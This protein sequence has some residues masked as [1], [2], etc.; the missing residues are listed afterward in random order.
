[1]E[2]LGLIVAKQL[3]DLIVAH[4]LD[5]IPLELSKGAIVLELD[6]IS[7]L[8][9]DLSDAVQFDQLFLV[10][11]NALYLNDKKFIQLCQLLQER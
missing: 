5:N 2:S 1:M 10:K 9:P 6:K 3:S 4:E 8:F 7:R 11:N